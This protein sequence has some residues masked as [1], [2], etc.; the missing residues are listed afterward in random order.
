MRKT[1]AKADFLAALQCRTQAWHGLRSDQEAS[2]E[3]DQFRMLQGQEVGA[4]AQRLF[5]GG[6]FVSGGSGK[7]AIEV[8]RELIRDA[9]EGVFFEAKFRS[10]PFVAKTDILIREKGN[11][12]ALEVKS[13]FSDTNNIDGLLDDLAY[14]VMVCRR[15]G[16]AIA[17]S[18][19]VLLSR[20]FRRGDG[21]DRLFE[22][23]D[24]TKEIT[25]RVAKFEEVAD[26]MTKALQSDRPPV[27]VLVPACRTC[28][29]F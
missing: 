15:A 1:L 6:T 23:L 7:S 3:A 18:S 25:G 26:D 4:L 29:H 24:K 19:L 8:T 28:P 22:F 12:H 27:P 21:P 13:S 9:Q 2:T 20:A 10:D 16:L 5:P 11:W 17:K 14:T